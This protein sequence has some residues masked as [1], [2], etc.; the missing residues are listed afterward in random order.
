MAEPTPD[1]KPAPHTDA[2]RGRQAKVSFG[3]F[4]IFFVFYVGSAVVQTPSCR[5]IAAIPVLGFPLGL[6]MSLAIFPVSWL[7][8]II[9]FKKAA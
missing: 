1:Q 2:H 4:F 7:I 9:W 3:L 8:I 6:V 5:A